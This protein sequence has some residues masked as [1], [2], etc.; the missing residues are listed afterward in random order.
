VRDDSAYGGMLS[1][2]HGSAWNQ[3]FSSNEFSDGATYACFETVSGGGGGGHDSHQICNDR[4]GLY[5][6]WMYF[7]SIGE[8]DYSFLDTESVASNLKATYLLWQNW[9]PMTF[10][11]PLPDTYAG[12]PFF[13]ST[14]GGWGPIIIGGM[15]STYGEN[16]PPNYDI[17]FNGVAPSHPATIINTLLPSGVP[18]T[19]IPSGV[20]KI[21]ESNMLNSLELRRAPTLDAGLNHIDVNAVADPSAPTISV[22]G[23]TGSSSYGPYFVVCHDANGG[24]TNVSPAS[25]TLTNGP[26]ALSASDYIKIS[27]S[28]ES[29]CASWDVLKG[30]LSEALATSVPGTATSLNDTGQTTVAYT[31]PTRNTTGD[32]A[33]GSILVSVGMPYAKI[34]AAVVNGGRFYCTDCDPPANPPAACT[35]IGA[36]TGSWVDGVNNQWLCVP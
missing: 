25:N 2:Q 16:Q 26:A 24:V 22:V 12:A 9:A 5:Y 13:E 27:W 11:S 1:F 19:D 4:G 23:A 10:I 35:H 20:Q 36:E 31:A 28:A 30:S 34:P 15:F 8:N 32:V 14:G 6:G 7:Q 18:L 17:F 33:Y 29:G 21:G 3:S